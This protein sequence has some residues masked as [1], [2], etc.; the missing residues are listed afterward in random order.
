M[1]YWYKKQPSMTILDWIQW[2]G[3]LIVEHGDSGDG[4]A[5]YSSWLGDYI[6]TTRQIDFQLRKTARL[7]SSKAT[8]PT[9][10]HAV[11]D[12]DRTPEYDQFMQQLRDFHESKGY[13]RTRSTSLSV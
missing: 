11:K 5:W 9:M 4:V 1:Y 2:L 13:R 6:G 3:S 8:L 12:I 10:S 7:F